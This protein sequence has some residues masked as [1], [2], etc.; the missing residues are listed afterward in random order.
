[1]S[2]VQELRAAVAA[3]TA[4]GKT[5]NAAKSAKE[6]EA[7][8]PAVSAEKGRAGP[9]GV[10]GLAAAVGICAG[11]ALDRFVLPHGGAAPAPVPVTAV[12]PEAAKAGGPV[13]TG[14]FIQ[15]DANNPLLHGSGGVTISDGKLALGDDFAVTPGPDYR[16]LLVPKPAI[17]AAGDIDK[18]MY[19]DLGPLAAFQGNQTYAVPAGV[20]LAK[21]P[22][23]VIWCAPYAALI[24]TADLS[25]GG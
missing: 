25:F 20:D 4:S 23:V 22:S 14:T 8:R 7:A 3:S 12:A 10:L 11:I 15:P 13:A 19:V 16:V 6:V 1:M 2:S 21:F 5:E 17:R 18:T 24:S 9:L